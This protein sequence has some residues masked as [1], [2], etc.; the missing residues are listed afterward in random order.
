[1]GDNFNNI[2]LFDLYD[3]D[4]SSDTTISNAPLAQRLKPC[5]L[6]EFIGQEHIL[7]KDK[8]L[9]RAI[10]GDR[11]TS[12]IFYGPPGVG[13][14]SLAKII[15]TTTKCSYYELNAVTSG[16]K[17]IKEMVE[18]ALENQ[19]MRNQKTILFIDEIHR[20]NKTQQDALLP[21][22]EKGTV[23]LIGATT[24]N[25]FFEVNKA[26]LSRSM[27][28]KLN[29]L[30]DHHIRKLINRALTDKEKGY[31]NIRININE[32]AIGFIC[33][34][35]NGDGRRALN[36]LEL[37][38][39]TTNKSEDGI[40]YITLEV[41]EECMQKRNVSYD[42]SGD[43]HYDVI[44]AFIKSMRGSD[45]NAAIHYLSRMLY[46]GEDPEFIARR[47]F[48]AASEDVGN[49]D[50]YAVLLANA[51]LNAV[52]HIGMPEAR[53]PLAQAVIY[54]STAP[55]SNAC[56]NAINSAIYDV[57]KDIIGE[58]PVHLRDK[59][60]SGAQILNP[61]SDYKYPHDYKN[62]YVYQQYLPDEL[63]DKIYYTPANLGY[64]K[65]VKER[66]DYLKGQR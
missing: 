47:V 18:K 34:N 35:S 3:D 61:G 63:I 24:E 29:L 21:H 58:V 28:F 5:S 15:A 23:I 31:G 30:E 40:I 60:Y 1:M 43:S 49:A 19:R 41:I 57:E 39:L 50:P 65:K 64:E 36:A 11:L 20:F 7:S 51:A 25:P 32:E 8:L 54:I 46:A 33:V 52:K 42:K 26:L 14:T 6:E 22:V 17:D 59:S 66:M 2:S 13:K 27:I 9:Y 48:I 45:A 53:I 44:S 37:A 4:K 12:L 56:Y 38:V 62:H 55:K 10:Q 16:I